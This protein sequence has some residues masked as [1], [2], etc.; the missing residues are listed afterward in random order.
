M[1]S[2]NGI[3]RLCF[4]NHGVKKGSVQFHRTLIE[5]FH[6][7]QL[8]PCSYDLTLW[9]LAKRLIFPGTIDKIPENPYIDAS[10]KKLYGCKFEILHILSKGYYMKP[11]EFLIASTKETVD[12]PDDIA[13]RFEG[14]SSLG[15]LGLTTHITAGFIDAGFKGQITLEM[16]NENCV[17]IK[18][19]PDMK[20]GQICFFKLDR[21]AKRPY[22]S[23]DLGSH[24]QNQLGPTEARG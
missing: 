23:K 22:G 18:I 15:R 13:G 24:Y 4:D 19:I 12:L 14:K 6:E 11:G 1:L 21:S 16:K 2:D 7:E 3:R 20:I 17:P 10:E 9:C 5:P 8:Q